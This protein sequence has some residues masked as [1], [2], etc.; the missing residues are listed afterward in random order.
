MKPLLLALLTAATAGMISNVR[1]DACHGGTQV[2]DLQADWSVTQ[3]P[4][5]PWSYR[6]G[7]SLLVKNPLPWVGAT[8]SGDTSHWP[9]S[10]PAIE[11]LTGNTPQIY[12]EADFFLNP[13]NI[14]FRNIFFISGD[15]VFVPGVSGNILWTAPT[16]GTV[17]ISGGYWIAGLRDPDNVCNFAQ[18][19]SWTLTHNGAGVS[20]GAVGD[21]EACWFRYQP[22]P[23]ASGAAG[24]AA[25]ENLAVHAGDQIVLSFHGDGVGVNFTITLTADSVDPITAIEDLAIT[26][27]Q[28]NLQNG[29]ANSLDAK[30]DAALNVLTDVN[31]SNDVGAC[32]SLAAFIS[33]VQA[34]RGKKISNAQ[35]D[36]LIGS[37]Q[38][39]QTV[40]NC[41]N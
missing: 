12:S 38:C 8:Y 31:L 4:N 2:Y 39:I 40:L 9:P 5:G 3:N 34:Q 15:V 25:L 26:V 33:A 37:A 16:S 29:I 30:L 13:F 27:I 41:T 11:K 35:A 36:Q 19:A 23:F 32:N 1:S 6:D 7:E 10:V 21:I 22:N 24:S 18:V 17:S 14:G 28:M 20:S